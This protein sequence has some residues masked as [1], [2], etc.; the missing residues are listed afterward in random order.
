MICYQ[1]LVP[2]MPVKGAI[3]QGAAVPL[4]PLQCRSG[5]MRKWK[6]INSAVCAKESN[7]D[8]KKAGRKGS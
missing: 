7:D 2:M 3:P 6:G 5:R 8:E 1:R 4:G